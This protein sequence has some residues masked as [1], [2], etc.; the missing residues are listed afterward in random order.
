MLVSSNGINALSSIK[1]S[2]RA[3]GVLKSGNRV[4]EP[5]LKNGVGIGPLRATSSLS[6]GALGSSALVQPAESGQGI[7]GQFQGQVQSVSPLTG[8]LSGSGQTTGKP[9]SLGVLQA[10]LT[11]ARQNFQK[12]DNSSRLLQ[13]GNS[14]QR[15]N[16]GFGISLFSSSLSLLG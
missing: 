15:I 12:I 2:S 11:A 7:L 14:G 3:R 1:S 8:S 10:G 9:R 13:A 6:G 4:N 5:R 16:G